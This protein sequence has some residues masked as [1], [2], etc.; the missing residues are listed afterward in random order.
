MM[1]DGKRNE[2]KRGRKGG[3]EGKQIMQVNNL[4]VSLKT[5][6]V[7]LNILTSMCIK[8]LMNSKHILDANFC[9]WSVKMQFTHERKRC[10]MVLNRTSPIS[11]YEIASLIFVFH[12][13]Q[14]NWHPELRFQISIDQC[15][16]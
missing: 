2:D 12:T 11:G 15:L 4:T 5:P 3:S 7:L 6:A 16:V 8:I 1:K 9:H 14:N 13:A 10:S